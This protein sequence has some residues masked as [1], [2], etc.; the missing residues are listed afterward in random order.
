[1]EGSTEVPVLIDELGETLDDIRSRALVAITVVI[2][3]LA[4]TVTVNIYTL[5]RL[6]VLVVNLLENIERIERFAN[7]VHLY[8]CVVT[9]RHLATCPNPVFQACL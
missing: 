1:M 6:A 8:Q 9:T 5:N 3:N 2:V 7:L 4:V